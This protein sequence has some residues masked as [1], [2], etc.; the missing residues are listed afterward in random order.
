[1]V[2][3]TNVEKESLEHEGVEI[4]V[5]IGTAEPKSEDFIKPENFDLAN[6]LYAKTA[7]HVEADSLVELTSSAMSTYDPNVIATIFDKLVR[8]DQQSYYDSL[9]I[10]QSIVLAK[11]LDNRTKFLDAIRH[12]SDENYV[13]EV[14]ADDENYPVYDVKENSVDADVTDNDDV[15]DETQEEINIENN[16]E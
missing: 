14:S 5:T 8:L 11:D 6:E 12:V 2:V 9:S 16:E 1:M 7:D 4:K 13:P 3:I 15:E 10:L